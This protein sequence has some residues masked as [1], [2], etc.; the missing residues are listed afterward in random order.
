MQIFCVNTYFCPANNHPCE[1]RGW[2]YPEII[3]KRIQTLLNLIASWSILKTQTG[4]L[5]SKNTAHSVDFTCHCSAWIVC[6]FA[7]VFLHTSCTAPRKIFPNNRR[8]SCGEKNSQSQEGKM[9]DKRLPWIRIFGGVLSLNS[10]RILLGIRTEA[11][12]Y[13]VPGP[14]IFFQFHVFAFRRTISRYGSKTM[15]SHPKKK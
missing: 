1:I 10:D 7:D 5:I 15:R 11:V 14:R 8:R 2:I 3:P 12:E 4:S 9:A 6:L 13:V